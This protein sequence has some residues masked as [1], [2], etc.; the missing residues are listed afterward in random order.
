MN[1]HTLLI[2]S[3]YSGN[4]EETLSALQ[5]AIK[6]NAQIVGITTGG[7]LE[8]IALQHDFP[9]VKVPSGMPPR[10]ALGYSVV[11]QLYILHQYHLITDFFEAQLQA[12]YDLLVEKQETLRLNA[13]RWS[14]F[15][16][17]QTLVIYTATEY[18]A[19]G[20]RWRQQLNENA[21]MLCWH[22]VLPEMNHNELVGWREQAADKAVIFVY[23]DDVF[24][25]T[26][27]RFKIVQKMLIKP[28]QA[29]CTLEFKPKGNSM[30]ERYIYGIHFG[31]WLSFYLS[32]ERGFDAMEIEAI[33]FLKRSLS[34]MEV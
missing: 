17:Q 10:A 6:Q 13:K 19:L 26:A 11:Q 14:K 25:R 22:N 7:Q 16:W 33:D 8:Q 32:Q 12:A 15:L 28:K 3:S 29:F 4:T 2:A 21:K 5:K 1:E 34:E 24:E 9:I 18:E 23:P 20:L 30:I 27:Y 31:D